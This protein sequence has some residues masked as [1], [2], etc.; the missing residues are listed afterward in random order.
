[1][2]GQDFVLNGFSQ[3]QIAG[4]LCPPSGQDRLV[5]EKT[6]NGI[7]MVKFNIEVKTYDSKNKQE[8]FTYVPI[9]CF[10]FEADRLGQYGKLN[11]YYVVTGNVNGRVVKTQNGEFDA[12]D[13]VANQVLAGSK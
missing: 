6:K 10:S 4:N 13:L 8:K 11:S 12:V 7:S 9:T 1:M 3:F 2:S 5:V